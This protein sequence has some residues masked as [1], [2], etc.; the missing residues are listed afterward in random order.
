MAKLSVT[1]IKNLKEPQMYADGGGLYLNVSKSG[2]KSWIFRGT[3]KGLTT[4]TGTPLRIEKGLG[5]VADV[6]LADA[7]K[8]AAVFHEMVRGGFNPVDAEKKEALTF[9]KA[10][11]RVHSNL[12]P[13]WRN[14]KHTETWLATVENYACAKFGNKPIEQVNSA[15]ILKVLSPIWI[16]KHET[17]KRLKQR[18]SAIFDWAKVAG[19]YPHDNPVN[20]IKISLPVVKRQ[21]R[22]MA[23]MP[24]QDIPML[25]AELGRRD[26][27]SARTVEFIILTAT[28]SGEARG[29]RWSEL[30]G[31]VWTIPG[32]RM[33]RGV[34]HR[35][36]LSAE[37]MEVLD[38]VRN[39]DADLMFPSVQRAKD[40]AAREQ[41]VM[42][43]K[44]L[45]GRMGLE[46]FTTHG[47]RSSFR[48]WCSESAR[49][50]W[51]VAEIALSHAVGNEVERAYAR[52]DLLERRQT[53]MNAWGQYA[54]GK[55]GEVVRMVR[56]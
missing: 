37:A 44:A 36:P 23:A 14:K 39:L 41:S 34:P 5:S 11:Q 29:A 30:D 20:G 2:T 3:V 24:W 35:V 42:V 50:D 27:V 31:N 47:F 45:Y 18:L 12:S 8:K 53:L 56:V 16:E 25:M 21:A 55:S 49:A 46:G 38:R 40:G 7:R 19:H 13:T 48:D 51:E 32:D 1:K 28:R 4:S 26:G 43:F 9:R 22:H 15:D 52:S 6:T 10:A 33:K 17:A 54:T